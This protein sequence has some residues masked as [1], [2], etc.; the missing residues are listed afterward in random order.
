MLEERKWLKCYQ[1][2]LASSRSTV[3]ENMTHNIKIER[4]NPATGAGGEK[5]AK[6]QSGLFGQ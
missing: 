3:A 5:M 2:S 1:D 6:M 4:L